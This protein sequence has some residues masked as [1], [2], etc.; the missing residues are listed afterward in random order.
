MPVPLAA[1]RSSAQPPTTS[2]RPTVALGRGRSV[3]RR[4]VPFAAIVGSGSAGT[5]PCCCALVDRQA[6]MIMLAMIIASAVP[7][8]IGILRVRGR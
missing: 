7:R 6:V 4:S 1:A 8:F 3:C 2:G 5:E